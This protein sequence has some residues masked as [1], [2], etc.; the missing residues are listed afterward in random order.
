MNSCIKHN[1]VAAVSCI[2]NGVVKKQDEV[3]VG[4][5]AIIKA[6]ATTVVTPFTSLSQPHISIHD[7]LER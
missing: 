5:I 1:I 4:V 7:Y 6:I 3:G 2:L